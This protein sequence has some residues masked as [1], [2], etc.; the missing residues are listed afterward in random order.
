MKHYEAEQ[1]IGQLPKI[2]GGYYYLTIDAEIVI[3]FEKKRHT[4]MIC[5]LDSTISFRCGLNHLGD[6]NFFVIVSGKYLEQL[7]K[8]LNS[9]IHFTLEEDPDQLGVEVPEVLIEVLQQ[10]AS[11]KNIYDSISDGKKRS[12]IYS[13]A[14][15]KNVDKQVTDIAT[16]LQKELIM[17]N[18]KKK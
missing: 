3:A 2:K 8:K 17:L 14:K 16:F 12:L 13:I 4:R 5:C 1:N 9:K 11:L 6:G 7:N 10:D 18:K 15:T